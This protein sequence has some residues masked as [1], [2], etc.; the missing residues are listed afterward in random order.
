MARLTVL[1]LTLAAAT[2]TFP[3]QSRAQVK[4]QLKFPEKKTRR[5]EVT[6]KVHQLLTRNGMEDETNTEL[7]MTVSL[8]MGKRQADDTI[9]VKTT[10]ESIFS[11]MSF[12]GG[13]ELT[14]DSNSP[15]VEN[16]NPQLQLALD[17]LRALSGSSYTAILDKNNRAVSVKRDDKSLEGASETVR[18]M[19]RGVLDPEYLKQVYN[20]ELDRLP[21][22]PVHQGDTW[23]RTEVSRLGRGQKFTFETLYEYVGTVEKEGKTL[24]KITLTT[25]SV[26]Y[27]RDADAA[28]QAKVTQSNL[29]IEE[30]SGTLFFDRKQGVVVEGR[31]LMRIKGDLTLSEGGKKVSVELDL[32]MENTSVL[33][34]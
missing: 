6:Q 20:Q 26:N 7:V 18:A 19:L 13:F 25:I 10:I 28:S 3:A 21:E 33:K 32:T 15:D 22:D 16:P 27:E 14:F 1:L 8:A 9:P 29:R 5:I 30:S 4:R 11:N 34:E 24:D 12:P 17:M 31:N 23:L 2:F